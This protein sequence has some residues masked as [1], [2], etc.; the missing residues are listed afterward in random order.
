MLAI[1][2][3]SK[4]SKDDEPLGVKMDAGP[5]V[6]GMD[7]GGVD[8]ASEIE[9]F[10]RLDGVPSPDTLVV[11]GGSDRAWRTDVNGRARVS[12]DRNV[13]GSPWIFASH[14]EARIW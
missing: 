9:V 6:I 4:P 10:V 8:V 13:E 14:P 12:L 7:T 11:Q 5:A 3:C 2:A 1:A